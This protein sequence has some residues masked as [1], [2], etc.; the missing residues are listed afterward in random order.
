ME[1]G[2]WSETERGTPQGAVISPPLANIY[3]HYVFDL[4]VNAW[5]KQHAQGDMVVVRY[6]DDTVLGFQSQ[7]EADRFLED[8]RERL[9]KFGLE[10][11]PGKTRRSE[12]GR[13]AEAN[14]KSRGEG[15]PETFDFLGFTHISGKNRRGYFTVKR[16][17]IRKR[18][19]AKLQEIKQQLQRRRHDPVAQTGEWLRSV[20]QGYFNYH[21]VPGNLDS[22]GTFR[23]RLIRLWRT[24]LRQRSQRYRLNWD[25][26]GTLAARWLPAPRV[27]HPWPTQRFAA[28]HPS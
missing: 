5:R 14:R 9:G 16:R 11:H 15:K 1:E 28:T 7:T 2:E 26:L 8:F 21:A 24:Q 25:R 20:V 27:L 17:T 12:F 13:Y 19:R 22:L 10:L 4:W 6:A 23:E 3:L 18:L